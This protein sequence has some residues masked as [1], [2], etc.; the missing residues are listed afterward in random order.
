MMPATT[1]LTP[2]LRHVLAAQLRA[3][4]AALRGPAVVAGVSFA[5]LT[6]LVLIERA[7]NSARV[8]AFHP[9]HQVLPG[10]LG[11]LLP[12]G[13]WRG[14]AP[15]G[16]GVL[17]TLP[18][19]RRTHALAKVFAGWAWL[20]ALVTLLVCWL[21]A[22][23]VASD[24]QVLAEEVRRIAP[25]AATARSGSLGPDAAA[26]VHTSAQPLLWLV[27]FTASTGTYL[28]ASALALGTRRPLAWVSGVVG[29]TLLLVTLAEAANADDLLRQIDGGLKALFY[30]RYGVDTLLTARTESLQGS[31][32]LSNGD[33]VVVWSALPD[34]TQWAVATAIWI[35]AGLASLWAAA[36]RHREARPSSRWSARFL[37]GKDAVGRQSQ[38]GIRLNGRKVEQ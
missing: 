21:L 20:M 4:G 22:L 3:T 34:L 10:L 37:A 30:G 6:V 18:V 26:F 14:E 23:V 16:R 28:F 15:F 36:F 13:V 32:T 27:P 1:G 5:L 29:G 12:F 35:A 11:L 33:T 24:G 19:D 31:A 2:R 38:Q 8:I 17:W 9:E 25:T 7:D